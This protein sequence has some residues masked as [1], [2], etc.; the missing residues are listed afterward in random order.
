MKIGIKYCGVILVVCGC[1]SAYAQTSDLYVEKG[2][3]GDKCLFPSFKFLVKG[4][5][6][7]LLNSN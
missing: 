3:T 2:A 1:I 7:P 6:M 5:R 4:N